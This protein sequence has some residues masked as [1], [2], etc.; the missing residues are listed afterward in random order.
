MTLVIVLF[1]S[2]HFNADATEPV[3][4]SFIPALDL[5]IN[6]D[7]AGLREGLFFGLRMAVSFTAGALLFAVTTMTELRKALVKAER[8]LHL[9]QVRLSLGIALMLGFIPRFFA[10]WE[11]ANLAWEARSGKKG[12][13]RFFILIPLVTERMMEAAAETAAALE[14][15]GAL[16]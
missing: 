2:L 13:G 11:D 12:A 10:V 4:K 14:A 5:D 7:I 8:F 16:L 1:Q 9:E 3:R 15:R 6:I